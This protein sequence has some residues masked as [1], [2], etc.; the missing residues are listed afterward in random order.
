MSWGRAG[1]EG[2]EQAGKWQNRF[3]EQQ[4]RPRAGEISGLKAKDFQA[5]AR[6]A[7]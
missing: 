3:K 6:R 4:S 1:A 7:L 5:E 2:W